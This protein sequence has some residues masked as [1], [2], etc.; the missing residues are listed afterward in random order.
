MINFEELE[1]L[2]V[3]IIEQDLDYVPTIK[4]TVIET[5]S[6]YRIVIDN[7]GEFIILEGG[8]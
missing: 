2:G 5:V 3:V 7:N 6:D 4:D 8:K 1:K